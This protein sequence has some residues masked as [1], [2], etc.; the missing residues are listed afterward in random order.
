MILGTDYFAAKRLVELYDGVQDCACKAIA[1]RRAT[2]AAGLNK[3]LNA[4]ADDYIE[5][6][7]IVAEYEREAAERALRRHASTQMA[8]ASLGRPQPFR[9][10]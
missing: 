6:Q 7:R 9:A 4:E 8:L 3:L 1:S 10:L 5:A 2:L